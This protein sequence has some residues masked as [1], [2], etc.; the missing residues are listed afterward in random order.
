MGRKS[1]ADSKRVDYTRVYVSMCA[2]QRLKAREIPI[3]VCD[4]DAS[5]NYSVQSKMKRS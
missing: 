1:D 5:V 3:K 4:L 2:S